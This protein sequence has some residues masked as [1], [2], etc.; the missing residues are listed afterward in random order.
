MENT[1]Y[2]LFYA[3]WW[4][5]RKRTVK[6]ISLYWSFFAPYLVFQEGLLSVCFDFKKYSGKPL[7][8]TICV[9]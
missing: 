8:Y 3:R 4:M 7:S 1:N 5:F 2:C 6:L 9:F